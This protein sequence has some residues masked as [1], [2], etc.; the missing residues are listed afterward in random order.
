MFCY[1]A[2]IC[3]D[4]IRHLR[5]AYIVD[6]ITTT[7]PIIELSIITSRMAKMLAGFSMAAPANLKHDHGTCSTF[8]I[9]AFFVNICPMIVLLWYRLSVIYKF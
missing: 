2:I 3:K 6:T 8:V 4:S 5:E 7:Q 9:V 1:W